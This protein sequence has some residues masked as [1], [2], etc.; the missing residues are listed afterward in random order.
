MAE[1]QRSEDLT[2]APNEFA[3]VLDRTIGV[4]HTYCG[5]SNNSLSAQEAPVFFDYTSKRF[6][7]ADMGRVKQ[8]KK[9]APEGW[10]IILKNPAAKGDQP[11]DGKKARLPELL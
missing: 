8:L 6:V 9:L 5:P 2:L 11:E 7:P 10:D 3:L 4:V 1:I